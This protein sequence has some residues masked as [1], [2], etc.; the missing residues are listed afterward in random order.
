[1]TL[2]RDDLAFLPLGGTGE[3]GMNLNLYHADGAWLA[4]DCGIGFGDADR[5]DIEIMVPDAGFLAERRHALRALVITH[6]HEDHLGAV[7]WLWPALECPVYATPFAAAV[8]RRKLAERQLLGRVPLATIEPGGGLALAPFDLR[9][10]RMAHSIPEAQAVAIRTRHGLVLHTGDWKLDPNPL[11]GPPTDEAALAALG[12]EG[13]DVMVC[14][15]T[16][17]MVEGHSGSEAE[18]RRNLTALIRRLKGRVA[19]TCFATN[20]ARI[21]SIALAAQSAGRSVAIVGRAFRNIVAA[22]RET[23][24]LASLPEF[25][26]EDEA[27]YLPDDSVLFLVAGSQGEPRSALSRIAADTHPNVSL[28]EGDTVIYSSRVIPGNER[29][30]LR[31]QDQFARR[32]VTVMTERDHMVHVSGHPARDELRRLYALVRPKHV[33]PVHGEWRHMSEHAALARELGAI[34]HVIEDG[35]I[36][37]LAPGP[38]TVVDSAPAGKLAVDGDRLLPIGGEVLAAR[39]RMLEHGLVVASL[40]LD[41]AGRLVGRPRLS[42]P[43]VF[44]AGANGAAQGLADDLAAAVAGLPAQVRRDDEAV[45]EAARGALRGL[46]RRALWQK[47]PVI[48]VHVMRLER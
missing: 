30:I 3:I 20:V 9:F 44:E 14:D 48:E 18:V 13:V 37:R 4:I 40:A 1:M 17:A 26:E 6:A 10:I 31:V 39:R 38:V 33:V 45:A 34:P 16:N 5:P 43:G 24:Y 15:S 27:G 32:G 22:A 28:G 29:A 23:G 19:V 42:G 21:E 11:V 36:L 46:L 35:D 8:L 25:V 47:R 7:A 12:E 41:G 2:A